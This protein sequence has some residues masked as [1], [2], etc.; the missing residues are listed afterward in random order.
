MYPTTKFSPLLLTAVIGF[1]FTTA[2]FYPSH[3]AAN[4]DSIFSEMATAQ[5]I[6]A[7]NGM[8]VS[9]EA[10]ASQIGV[11]IL[12]QGGNAIDAAVAVGFALAVTLPRAGNIG[13]GGFM[14]VHI[15]K[16]NKTI[17]ID[18]RETAP[19]K[20]HKDIFLDEKGNAV[21][22]LSEFRNEFLRKLSDYDYIAMNSHL[23]K[24]LNVKF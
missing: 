15:A 16:D 11:D 9:Q 20:A 6:F 21:D 19:G 1:S 22:K 7:K 8:V 4:E 3:V 13:G 18:Y 24:I 14:L 2:S 23:F 17:A 10:I 12:K 5:P